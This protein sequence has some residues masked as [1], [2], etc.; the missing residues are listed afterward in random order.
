MKKIIYYDFGKV[1]DQ[2]AVPA[3]LKGKRL[4][5]V[6]AKTDM[7]VEVRKK[8]REQGVKFDPHRCEVALAFKSSQRYNIDYIFVGS[9][10]DAYA[11]FKEEDE[12]IH[13]IIRNR[14]AWSRDNF[15]KE[16]KQMSNGT[17]VVLYRSAQ[18]SRLHNKKESRDRRRSELKAGA[19]PRPTRKRVKTRAFVYGINHR[20]RAPIVSS[21]GELE[22]KRS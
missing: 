7:M 17:I 9:G 12:V 19:K 3:H 20:V 11:H 13:F 15:D 6:E 21:F 4:I 14:E 1:K 18:S 8:H 22:H 2:A 5:I 16:G 10:S